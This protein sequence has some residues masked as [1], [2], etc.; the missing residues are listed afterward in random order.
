MLGRLFLLALTVILVRNAGTKDDG[1]TALL[2]IVFAFTIQLVTSVPAP[3]R[4]R[5]EHRPEDP[6]DRLRRL[7]RHFRSC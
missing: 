7:H 4:V 2:V 5:D 6:A 1:L 3:A